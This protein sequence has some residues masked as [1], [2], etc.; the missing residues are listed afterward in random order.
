MQAWNNQGGTQYILLGEPTFALDTSLILESNT[1]VGERILFGQGKYST[2]KVWAEEICGPTCNL[3]SIGPFV[4]SVSLA[5]INLCVL[6]LADIF[7]W[8]NR[9]NF[10]AVHTIGCKQVESNKTEGER[11]EGVPVPALSAG[12]AELASSPACGKLHRGRVN[13]DPA[14]AQQKAEIMM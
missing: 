5:L 1:N 7:T 14:R 12:W 11:S 10:Y 8:A 6:F 2:I 4:Q 13:R 9:L 3:N